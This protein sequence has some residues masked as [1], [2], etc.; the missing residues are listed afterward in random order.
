[1]NVSVIVINKNRDRI[2]GKC[3]QSIISQL[4]RNDQLIVIDDNSTDS[5]IEVINEYLYRI[6][7]LL[8]IES[9]G[10]RSIVRNR[11]ADE[12]RNDIIIFMD[13]DVV[14]NYGN[15][16]FVKKA[17]EDSCVVGVNGNVFGNNHD[18]FQF[19]FISHVC[20]EDFLAKLASNFDVLYDYPC[21]FDYRF[22]NKEVVGDVNNNWYYYYTSFASVRRDLFHNVGRFDESMSGWGAEDLDLGYRLNKKGKLLF[23]DDI[24]S[25]HCPHEKNIFDIIY[26]KYSI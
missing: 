8:N 7:C 9:G 15:I 1:M 22:S 16:S 18:K 11:A 6:D 4:E 5:S 23:I 21:F 12:A 2:I 13:S 14:I 10:S 19:E 3:L 24:I 17:H 25:F 26:Q 20:L